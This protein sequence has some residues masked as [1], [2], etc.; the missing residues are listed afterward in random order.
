MNKK[1]TI[2]FDS[3]DLNGMKKIMDEHGSSKFLFLAQMKMEKMLSS[4]SAATI[5]LSGPSSIM[6]GYG[7]PPIGKTGLVKK[8]S[9]AVRDSW[10]GDCYEKN[11]KGHSI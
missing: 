10:T 7:F 1:E 8:F 9:R 4:L 11:N 2:N 5:S 3:S 6:A